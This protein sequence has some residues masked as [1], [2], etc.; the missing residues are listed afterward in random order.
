M[1]LITTLLAKCQ[2]PQLGQVNM[3]FLGTEVLLFKKPIVTNK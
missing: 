3:K 2:E 1:I